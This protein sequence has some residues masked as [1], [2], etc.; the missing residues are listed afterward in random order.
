MKR[1]KQ[2][3]NSAYV[4]KECIY[5]KGA[6]LLVFC[7]FYFLPSAHA[8]DVK[9]LQPL[10]PYGV[11]STF[12]AESL[13]QN[14]VGIGIGLEKSFDPDFYRSNFQMAYG[15]H[16]RLELNMSVPYVYDW[17]DRI[18]GFEDISMGIKHRIIDEQKYKPAMAYILTVSAASGKDEFTTDGRLGAGLLVSK[19]VGPFKG[20][21]NLFYSNP[22]DSDLDDEYS[23]NIGTEL[24]VSHNST[25]LAE[26]VGKK[27][28]FRNRINLFEWRLGYRV[29]TTDNIF[30]T[31]GAGFDI[32]KRTPDYRF[33]FSISII[34]P[35]EK[36]PLRTI[37]E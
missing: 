14:K 34:L 28:Y 27:D 22:G 26:I 29:A 7:F 17:Q 10:S 5:I 24:A 2:K 9:G 1:S 35:K 12:S 36:K 11:F 37:Y 6:F 15:L 8:F 33:I 18:D 16:D 32:K 4:N 31:I 20:H 25:I 13:K 21:L 3:R 23:L 19:K 30:T